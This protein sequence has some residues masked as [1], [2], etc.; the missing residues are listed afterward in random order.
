MTDDEPGLVRL[1][2]PGGGTAA[3]TSLVVRHHA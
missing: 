2:W 3:M 1:R